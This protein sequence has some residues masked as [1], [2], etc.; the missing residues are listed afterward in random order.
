MSRHHFRGGR[1]APWLALAGTAPQ[2]G[3]TVQKEYSDNQWQAASAT[4]WRRRRRRE[5]EVSY[6][7]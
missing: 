3:V 4:D 2:K 6:E 1:G 5:E 7:K